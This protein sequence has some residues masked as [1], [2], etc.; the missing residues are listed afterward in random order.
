[1]IVLTLSDVQNCLVARSFLVL[2]LLLA[3][4]RTH[5]WILPTVSLEERPTAAVHC[6]KHCCKMCCK[7]K[8]KKRDFTMNT[9][10][11]KN[12][13]WQTIRHHCI[14]M[15]SHFILYYVSSAHVINLLINNVSCFLCFVSRF[16]LWYYCNVLD[17]Y[18]VSV[19]LISAILYCIS[20]PRANDPIYPRPN[21]SYSVQVDEVLGLYLLSILK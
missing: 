3:E 17:I 12:Y 6:C 5:F 21:F 16:F 2:Y 13:K 4:K 15:M 10:V 14:N 19:V 20:L 9:V 1:M 11:Y 7:N 18:T 8:T